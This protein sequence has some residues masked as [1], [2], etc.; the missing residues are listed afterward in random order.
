[1]TK[2]KFSAEHLKL[3]ANLDSGNI[4]AAVSLPDLS[5]NAQ[6]FK[7]SSLALELDVQR[8]G[9]DFQGQARLAAVGKF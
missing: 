2:D 3:N 5:G 4:V 6:S 1:M 7:V 8:A 9:S